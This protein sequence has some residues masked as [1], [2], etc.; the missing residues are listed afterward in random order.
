LGLWIEPTSS[1][2]NLGKF[3]GFAPVNSPTFF[4]I[5]ASIEVLVLCSLLVLLI[6]TEISLLDQR[7]AV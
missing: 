3:A 4:A 1:G 2:A 5:A 7:S 6:A